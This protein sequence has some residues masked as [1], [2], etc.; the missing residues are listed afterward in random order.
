MKFKL[1]S[2]VNLDY[3][4]LNSLTWNFK[5][6]CNC[7]SKSSASCVH[8]KLQNFIKKILSSDLTARWFVALGLPKI[9][10]SALFQK[11]AWFHLLLINLLLANVIRSRN[12][13]GNFTVCEGVNNAFMTTSL[14]KIMMLKSRCNCQMG[15]E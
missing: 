14:K 5:Q 9:A 10:E 2:L 1:D 6:Y 15:C 13:S 11:I 12:E 3:F 7:K 8:D 4:T